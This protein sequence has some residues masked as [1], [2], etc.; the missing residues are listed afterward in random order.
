MKFI[1]IPHVIIH[2]KHSVLKL[3]ASEDDPLLIWRNSL[4]VLNLLQTTVSMTILNTNRHHLQ[5][6]GGGGGSVDQ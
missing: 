6:Q 5:I 2:Q 1:L 4:F 3:F